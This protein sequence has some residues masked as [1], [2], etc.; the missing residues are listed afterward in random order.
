ME[1]AELQSSPS[2]TWTNYQDV[3]PPSQE[4][5]E[6]NSYDDDFVYELH[7][8]NSRGSGPNRM[9]SA[10]TSSF[11]PFESVSLE[12][13]PPSPPP[14]AFDFNAPIKLL[15]KKNSRRS[16]VDS[17]QRQYRRNKEQRTKAMNYIKGLLTGNAAIAVIVGIGVTAA[18]AVTAFH[19]IKKPVTEIESSI[20]NDRARVTEV[21]E[22]CNAPDLADGVNE[23]FDKHKEE[24]TVLK[25]T[26]KDGVVIDTVNNFP[27]FKS[28]INEKE[29]ALEHG[30]SELKKRVG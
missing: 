2:G 28:I 23:T 16:E 19:K 4:V 18:I 27:L 21:A 13:S 11:Q 26:V 24:V 5:T 7:E 9:A 14:P 10:V 22:K 20:A 25:L 15:E 12:V 8:D 29:A 30:L 1:H 6:S 3:S 17:C